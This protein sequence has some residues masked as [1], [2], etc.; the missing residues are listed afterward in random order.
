M[1]DAAS[2]AKT[3]T[4]ILKGQGIDDESAA[5]YAQV[6]VD[7]DVDWDLAGITKETL[8]ELG[9]TKIGHQMKILN[10]KQKQ[11]QQLQQPQASTSPSMAQGSDRDALLLVI[12]LGSA[13][14]ANHPDRQA[15]VKC[16]QR[17]CR[18]NFCLDCVSHA[19]TM[20]GG[21]YYWCHECR[22]YVKAHALCDCEK[23]C[24]IQ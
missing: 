5:T 4:S 7:Q 6:L 19:P 16:C 8:E 20:N 12:S 15:A 3:W 9:I 2:K 14:C 18:K 17:N 1:A 11:E 23:C 22:D 10:Y 24:V 13:R 21:Q